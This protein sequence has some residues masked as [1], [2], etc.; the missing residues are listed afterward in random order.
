MITANSLVLYKNKPALIKHT[1]DK[2]TLLFEDGSSLRVREKDVELIHSGPLTNFPDWKSKLQTIETELLAAWEIFAGTDIPFQELLETTVSSRD[3]AELLAVYIAIESSPLFQKQGTMVHVVSSEER[4]QLEEKIEKKLSAVNDKKD[5]LMR[6][7]RGM[8][9]PGDERFYGEIEAFARGQTVHSKIAEELGIGNDPEKAHAW[10]LKA[11]IWS[12]YIN[13][14][15]TRAHHPLKAPNFQITPPI[16]S[17]REDYSSFPA[18][19]IDNAW[20][21]DPDDAVGWDGEAILI[22]IAD[23]SAYVLPN[24]EI[25][26]EASNRGSTLYLPEGSI[27]ML[28]EALIKF[29]GLGLQTLSRTLTFRILIHDDGSIASVTMKPGFAAI[30]RCTYE[31]A[32]PLIETTE[33]R[34]LYEIAQKRK[35]YREARGAVTINKPEVHLY[36]REGH[37][38]IEPIIPT[39]ASELVQEMMILAG[40]AVA[41]WAFEEK[42]PFPFYCQDAPVDR[43]S[44]PPGLAGMYARLRTMKAGYVSTSPRAHHGL[45]IS[46]Y[47]QV[48]SPL[49]RYSDLLAHQQ[50]RSY[51]AKVYGYE[52]PQLLPIDEITERLG[53]ASFQISALRKAEKASELHWTLVWLLEHPDWTGTGIVVQ[54]GSLNQIYIP[55]IG[56]ETFIK[57]NQLAINDTVQLKLLKVHLPKLEAVFHVVG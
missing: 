11:G 16:D 39:P 53:R 3:P 6:A 28:P 14:H 44:F 15:P 51:L 49:R 46:M 38:S 40:E 45:G 35:Q 33:L 55:E 25:D 26:R 5:F 9:Q 34:T 29:C 32:V 19:A 12:P 13:P 41:W 24:S 22:H 37:P 27:P 21:H 50:I 43:T 23:P 57:G 1:D 30:T 56:L 20:S 47:T 42:L 4:A 52:Y 10:L 48:T 17:G 7:S 8:I 54:T 2:L 36:V 18:W 31:S